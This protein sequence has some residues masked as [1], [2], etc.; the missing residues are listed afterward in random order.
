MKTKI[1][2]VSVLM[3]ML[4]MIAGG[5][6][7]KKSSPGETF[8]GYAMCLAEKNYEGYVDG[9]DIKTEGV[10]EEKVKEARN[11]LIGLLSLSAGEIDKKGGL[12]NVEVLE[13]TIHEG[14]TTATV[15]VKYVYGD[16]ST[17]EEKVEMVK[18]GSDWKMKNA[19]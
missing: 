8:K 12:K 16:A 19:K 5:C 14:D 18:R 10:S 6:S 13:E 4:A 2:I 9:V 1:L 3:T 11:T 15:K 7:G 17:K